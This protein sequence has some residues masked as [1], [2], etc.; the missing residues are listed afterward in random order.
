MQCNHTMASRLVLMQ[1]SWKI[2]AGLPTNATNSLKETIIK[3]ITTKYSRWARSLCVTDA[4]R[5]F[6][7]TKI[8]EMHFEPER[9]LSD[10]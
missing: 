7:F 3:I 6:E 2:F 5:E 10:I 1:H 9:K 4:S 8:V